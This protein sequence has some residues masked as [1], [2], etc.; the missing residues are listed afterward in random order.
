MEQVVFSYSGETTVKDKAEDCRERNFAL[1][2]DKLFGTRVVSET[3]S[4]E[5]A[6]MSKSCMIEEDNGC[7]AYTVDE[8]IVNDKVK[9]VFVNNTTRADNNHG[10]TSSTLDL[11]T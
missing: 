7:E 6:S 10:E 5:D 9:E 11:E 3:S 4:D 2:V 1:R 8:V